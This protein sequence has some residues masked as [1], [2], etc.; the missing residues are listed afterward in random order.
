MGYLL[1]VVF[2]ALLSV[3]TVTVESPE[4]TGLAREHGRESH[5]R[6]WLFY[7]LPGFS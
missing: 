3:W 1:F 6:E 7:W 5:Y 2:L 4:R